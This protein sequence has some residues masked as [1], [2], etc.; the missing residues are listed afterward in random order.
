MIDVDAR[1]VGILEF[2]ASKTRRDEVVRQGHQAVD[3]FLAGWDW[4]AYRTECGGT[5][6]N[7]R[8]SPSSRAPL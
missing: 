7:R 1:A 2:E 8:R 3:R 4:D 6:P 5:R